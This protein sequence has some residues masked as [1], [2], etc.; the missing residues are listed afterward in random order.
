VHGHAHAAVFPHRPLKRGV[1]D[2]TA[3]VD[4]LAASEPLAVM[5]LLADPQP[6]LGSGQSEF[7]RGWCWFAP[8]AAVH[9]DGR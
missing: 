7:V 8:L 2:L 3:A 1:G 5:H 9:G 4:G 6:V